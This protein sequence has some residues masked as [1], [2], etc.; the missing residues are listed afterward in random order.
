MPEEVLPSRTS[1]L[2]GDISSSNAPFGFR[3]WTCWREASEPKY[4]L[5]IDDG[6][7][8]WPRLL[9]KIPVSSGASSGPTQG[10]ENVGD[11]P[12][13]IYAGTPARGESWT[14]GVKGQL[15]GEAARWWALKD[16]N[17]RPFGCKPN[18]LTAELSALP[19]RDTNHR[20]GSSQKRQRVPEWRFLGLRKALP[21]CGFCR[22]GAQ[23]VARLQRKI[24]QRFWSLPCTLLAQPVN[25]LSCIYAKEML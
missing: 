8:R 16:L 2:P 1:Q 4:L 24:T 18:A 19:I 3:N 15:K 7:R 25:S 12:S 9:A 17:L 14:S 11:P 22:A 23:H 6:E 21:V 5:R 13:L 10:R 20:I